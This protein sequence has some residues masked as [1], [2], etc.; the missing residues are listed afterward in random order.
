MSPSASDPWFL[1]LSK[2]RAK[3]PLCIE[4]TLG[5]EK[6]EHQPVPLPKAGN[7]IL[8]D[9]IL[10]G[11]SELLRWEQVSLVSAASVDSYHLLRK[12]PFE[13]VYLHLRQISV[14]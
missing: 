13:P 14:S 4:S 2:T 6:V 7:L 8:V 12:K 5:L 9:C 10:P 1:P 11:L 3:T